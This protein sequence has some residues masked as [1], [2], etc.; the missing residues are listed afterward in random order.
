M[1]YI[2]V[3]D[4]TTQKDWTEKFDSYYKFRNRVYRLIYSKKLMILSRSNL[5]ED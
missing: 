3:L 5:E 2:H 4:T 1:Y